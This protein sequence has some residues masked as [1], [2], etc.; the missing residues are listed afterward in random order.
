MANDAEFPRWPPADPEVAAAL[1]AAARDGLWGQYHGSHVGGLEEEL[2][3]YFGV[4]H[5]LT[6][7]SGTLA[8][9]AA[10][11]AVGVG[12]GDEVVLGSYE[13]ESN[14]LTIHAIGAKPV[15][16]DV[17]PG[18]AAL[19][20]A[21]LSEAFTPA[22][23]AVLV[24]HLHGTV[25]DMPAV[26]AASESRGV[27]VVEDAAQCPG[28][29]LGGKKVGSW[30]HAGVISFG[31]SKLLAAGRGGALFSHEAATYQRAKV[32]LSRGIQQWAAI[33]ELQA[34]VLRPQL[35]RLDERTAQRQRAVVRIVQELADVPGITP[36]CF[37]GKPGDVGW[38]ERVFERRPTGPEETLSGSGGS[39]PAKPGSTHPTGVLGEPGASAIGVRTPVADAP[40]SPTGYSAYY[41]VGFHF[42]ESQFGLAREEFCRLLR[43][44]GIAFDPGFKALHLSR[45]PSRFRAVG[46]LIESAR[47]HSTCVILHHPVLLGS[48]EE[49][50]H[51][52]RAVRSVYR[53]RT[54][55]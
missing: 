15:F 14:F 33:S 16:V 5:V 10:L 31:G 29:V 50:G 24:S 40:G 32:W 37:F 34:A 4:P 7:A 12:P 53:K 54:V 1:A 42:D 20:P 11:R 55:P 9:E 23:K 30:G 44:E 8:V 13:Y 43:A 35:K 6:C 38:V 27:K 36:L 3:A 47:L 2:A 21:R 51:V 25:A 26:L 19:D 41:K 48:V 52:A 18:T 46:D 49:I 45:A 22:T 28:A 17:A 39:S